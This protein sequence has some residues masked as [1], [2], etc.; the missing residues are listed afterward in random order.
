[1]ASR[2]WVLGSG[3]W[4][5]TTTTNWSASTG[6]LG[7]ASAPTSAD[8]VI[9]DANSNVLAT[10]FTVTLGANANCLSFSTG[11]AGG[12]LDG[13]MTFNSP[14][15]AI[16]NV[17]GS[18]TLPASKLT[19]APT[20]TFVLNFLSTT[21]GNTVTTNGI[22]LGQTL[23]NFNG[24]GG[25]WTLGSAFAA[26]QNIQVFAGTFNTGNYNVT[27]SVFVS[28]GA[29]TR[30]CNLG[31]STV[32]VIN[33]TLSF[34]FTSTGLT[35]NAGTS[36]LVVSNASGT[37][38]GAGLTFYNVSYTSTA[39]TTTVITGA[40][41]YNNL[42]F[43]GKSAVGISSI[44]IDS[45]LTVNG[46]LTVPAPT[47]L[48]ASRY[49]LFGTTYGTPVTITAAA[50]SFT[51]TDFRD[52]T[53]A[54]TA[55]WTGTRLG[56]VGG[57]TGI[58]FPT[59]K[60][61]YWNLA[62]S[63]FISTNGWAATQTGAPATTNFPLPQDTAT[64]TDT[65]PASGIQIL[66]VYNY[67]FGTVSFSARTLPLTVNFA[68]GLDITKDFILS[69]AIT[70]IGSSGLLYFRG[71]NITQNFTSAGVSIALTSGI[72]Q[73]TINGTLQFN[74]AVTMAG[75][76]TFVWGTLSTNYNLTCLTF[77]ASGTAAKGYS[78]GAGQLYV[79]GTGLAVQLTPNHTVTGTPTINVTSTG[80]TAITVANSIVNIVNCNFTGGTY[81]LTLTS[82]PSRWYNNLNFTGFAG[83]I[84]VG[85]G[86][87][88][89]G[90][91]TL[92]T[93]MDASLL[94]LNIL[95]TTNQSIT[96]NSKTINTLTVIK[97]AGTLTFNDAFT[98]SGAFTHTSGSFIANY[99]L[100]CASLNSSNTATRAITFGG[101]VI[102]LTGTGTV[103][104]T[105]TSTGLTLSPGTS[106]IALTN[107]STTARTFAGGGLTYNNLDIGG[108]T[109]ISTTTFTGANTFNTISSTK[110]VA[111]TI[112]FTA[113]TTTRLANWLVSG[114]AGNVVTI[115]S[116]TAASHNLV[117][118]GSRTISVDYMSISRSNAS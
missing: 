102:S 36:T 109:G 64:F 26:S 19:W 27:S 30:T 60:T 115:G 110:T 99:N 68:G 72:A 52:I 104:D 40:N 56:D 57:N 92:S 16:L 114:T 96:S 43:A 61:V 32:T 33:P 51:D 17:Y 82:A 59:S 29:L 2:F 55:T 87:T 106:K 45:N 84:V 66:N 3:T 39:I 11:G 81:A 79:T 77:T 20:S 117:N 95:G 62:G 80:S 103:W 86:V 50:V 97:T 118:T 6:G 10:A 41:T 71:R 76:Y 22:T 53:G 14:A 46:T 78:L 93:G 12:A 90:D 94:A 42:T 89:Y 65:N 107:T 47:T 31:S 28:T 75:S 7:G 49:L 38:T 101:N 74:D 113:A 37:F 105:T 15:S 1:M 4:D 70:L 116:V 35:F 13:V 54:G 108:A 83:S 88:V 24:V 69:T 67:T 98:A 44:S 73:Y 18:F 21:T 63:Q 85:S 112:L 23:V 25:D 34:Q 9:F 58:T 100:T 8:D 111:H 91:L 48:G 5:T